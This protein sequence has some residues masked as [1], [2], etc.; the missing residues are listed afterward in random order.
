MRQGCRTLLALTRPYF[1]TASSMSKTFAVSR[2]SGGVKQQP[3]DR[4]PAGL[5]IALEL[6]A[7]RADLV[8]TLERVHALVEAAFG[9]R[10][11][12]GGEFMAGGMGRRYYTRITR[13]GHVPGQIRL[14]LDLR[15]RVLHPG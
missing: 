13:P 9:C 1:G 4:H 5:E 2:K 8:R 15:S 10:D 11:V 6:R 14:H 3:V 12:L 7:A